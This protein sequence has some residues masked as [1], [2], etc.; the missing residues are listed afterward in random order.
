VR[1]EGGDEQGGEIMARTTTSGD[2]PVVY[3][4][5]G[6][7]GTAHAHFANQI[8]AWRDGFRLLPVDLPGHGR[9]PLDAAERYG[10][11][12]R[13]YVLALLDRF[14]PGHLIAASYLGGPIAVRCAR[15]RPDLVRSL[16]LTGFAPGLPRDVFLGWIQGFTVLADTNQELSR[17]Y[18]RLHGPRWRYTL[19]AYGG[20]AEQRY[21]A[22]ILVTSDVLGELPVPTLIANGSLKAAE[23]SAAVDGATFGPR[24]RGHVIDGAGHIAGADA[25]DEFNTVVESF[26]EQVTADAR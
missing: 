17:E 11:T 24:V 13:G 14:G 10:E 25:P 21:E 18:D 15:T 16:V 3:F 5:H 7:L 12:A 9:C 23:R 8:R 19:A 20:D 2:R 22:S 26:W 1:S 4:L 6:L